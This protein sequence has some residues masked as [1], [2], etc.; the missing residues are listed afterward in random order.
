[1][2]PVARGHLPEH[3]QGN[4]LVGADFEGATIGYSYLAGHGGIPA[5]D[6]TVGPGIELRDFPG[7]GTHL[8][9]MDIS[10]NSVLIHFDTAASFPTGC[11]RRVGRN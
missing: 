11:R 3:L 10:N 4:F 9:Y 7:A 2:S 5:R 1:M 6:L 8:G